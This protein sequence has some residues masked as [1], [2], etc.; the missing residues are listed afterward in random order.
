M[1][2]LFLLL[3]TSTIFL[4]S[5]CSKLKLKFLYNATGSSSAINHFFSL[6][7]LYLKLLTDIILSLN[8]I[9]SQVIYL[10]A[11]V[12]VITEQS[13]LHTLSFEGV[14]NLAVEATSSLFLS[15]LSPHCKLHT[16]LI[17]A[18]TVCTSDHNYQFSLLDVTA[19]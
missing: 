6:L 10:R 1:T 15:L 4:C 11:L 16:L 9:L 13:N 3:F 8:K 5:S 19:S 14:V 2:A 17:C 7:L 18:C 12:C